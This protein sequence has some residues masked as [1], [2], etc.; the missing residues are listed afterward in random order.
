MVCLLTTSCS[1]IADGV[2][3][4][5]NHLGSG[6]AALGTFFCH[7][8]F[9]EL[10]ALKMEISISIKSLSLPTPKPHMMET[11]KWFYS[12]P[13][14]QLKVA[15]AALD[16]KISVVLAAFS[17]NLGW[18]AAEGSGCSGGGRAAP[19]ALGV[20]QEEG[21]WLSKALEMSEIKRPSQ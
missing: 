20:L 4:P 19:A 5:V 17:W 7:Q 3:W 2:C 13:V 11:Q 18:F 21:Q 8:L 6:K 10:S 1:G 15:G 14:K 12:V 16:E 9:G